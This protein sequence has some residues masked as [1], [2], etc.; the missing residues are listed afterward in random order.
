M[1]VRFISLSQRDAYYLILS[2]LVRKNMRVT[3][4]SPP[5]RIEVVFGSLVS[6]N[7]RK[8]RGT[9][10]INITQEDKDSRI[11]IDFNFYLAFL[12]Q[13]SMVMFL[14]LL[15]PAVLSLLPIPKDFFPLTI[16]MV[17]LAVLLFLYLWDVGKAKERFMEDFDAFLASIQTKNTPS[18]TMSP[19]P[20]SPLL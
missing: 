19:Q 9:A 13:S 16:C 7:P 20:L 10:V 3:G 1:G 11:T 15:S 5:N 8:G 17:F 12:F 2:Y 4:F 6:F 14:V 18:S